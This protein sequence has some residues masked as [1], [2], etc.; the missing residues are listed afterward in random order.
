MDILIKQLIIVRLMADKVDIFVRAGMRVHA[1]RSVSRC[2]AGWIFF[3]LIYFKIPRI[4]NAG[5]NSVGRI[6]ADKCVHIN[7]HSCAVFQ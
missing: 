5:K 4:I 1:G 7:P 2:A 3:I 6:F